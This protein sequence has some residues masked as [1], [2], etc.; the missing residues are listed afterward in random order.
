MWLQ[1]PCVPA[2]LVELCCVDVLHAGA[3]LAALPN[4]QLAVAPEHTLQVI[5]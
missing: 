1:Q 5:V 3:D 4:T 2:H